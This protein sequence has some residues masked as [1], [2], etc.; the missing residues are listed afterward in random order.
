MARGEVVLVQGPNGAGKST[1]LRVI[2]GLVPVVRGEAFVLGVDLRADRRAVR[3]RVGL[4]GHTALLYDDLTVAENVRFAVRAAGGD[5]A[6]VGP[7]LERV[8]LSGRL[9]RTPA[10]N[11]SAGQRRRAAL[12]AIVA[13][14]PELWL[15]DEPH[16]GLDAAGRELLDGLVREAAAGGATVVLVS[17]EADRAAAL[18]HRSVAIAG[19]HLRAVHDAGA[20]LREAAGVA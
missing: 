16:A 8:G 7:A 13:R 14:H 10:G 20:P 5:P 3:R 15:L 11:L 4:L 1:L 19:G 6:S 17:H 18:A 12:A 2:A 9:A